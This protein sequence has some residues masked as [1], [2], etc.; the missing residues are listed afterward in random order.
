MYA[1]YYLIF[2]IFPVLIKG[3]D[4]EPSLLRRRH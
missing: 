2:L 4:P 3:V 1:S